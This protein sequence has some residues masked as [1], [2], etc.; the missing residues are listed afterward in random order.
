[1][2]K[3]KQVSFTEEGNLTVSGVLQQLNS[4]SSY[5]IPQN[6]PFSIS[7]CLETLPESFDF[8]ILL[9]SISCKRCFKA[10]EIVAQII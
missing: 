5:T 7:P 3:R 9:H 4:Y 8:V 6:L 10:F 2:G 1:M